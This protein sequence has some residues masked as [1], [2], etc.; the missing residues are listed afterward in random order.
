MDKKKIEEIK[1]PKNILEYNIPDKKLKK[2]LYDW[3]RK[4]SIEKSRSKHTINSYE[5]DLRNFINFLCWH[6][7]NKNISL[8]ELDLTE[9]R[10]IKEEDFNYKKIELKNKELTGI[11]YQEIRPY[12]SFLT[13]L[14]YEKKSRKRIISAIK[15]FYWFLENNDD[16][17]YKKIKID[18]R[19]FSDLKGPKPE[20]SL[21][22][23][24][25]INVIWKIINKIWNGDKYNTE[26]I[27]QRD[28]AIILIMWGT[29]LRINEALSIKYHQI[30]TNS[31]KCLIKVIGKGKKDREVLL[32]PIVMRGINAYI[33]S[34]PLKFQNDSFIFVDKNLNKLDAAIFERNFREI[35]KELGLYKLD[36]KVQYRKYKC[37]CGKYEGKKYL[38][39][40]CE[41]CDTKIIERK[42]S[43]QKKDLFSPHALRH[44][45]GSH[46]LD[47]NV[48][49]REIQKMMGHA[50][51]K[52]TEK[53]TLVNNEKLRQQYIKFNPRDKIY[54]KN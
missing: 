29:G 42:R 9:L 48:D 36:Q 19:I 39:K 3:L 35:G 28:I 23:P 1:N 31:S 33:N 27:K 8:D 24:I 45:F 52:D 7:K 30:P 25:K 4:L 14:N 17:G 54:T 2:I 18:S 41:K 53:Y 16:T 11:Q 51:L 22:R 44:S 49:I 40:I 21:P 26:W 37:S 20:E 5:N 13:Y 50:S 43:E 34:C 10:R 46:L 6:K 38:N 32:L 15:N 12:L 47:N